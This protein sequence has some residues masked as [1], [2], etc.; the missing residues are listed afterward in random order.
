MYGNLPFNTNIYSNSDQR[1]SIQ[2]L[3]ILSRKLEAF[4]DN[5]KMANHL[6]IV[7]K[8][9]AK[10]FECKNINPNVYFNNEKILYRWE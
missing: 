5:C 3:E 8:I 2:T 6:M 1:S 9:F 7:K 4:G 10:A